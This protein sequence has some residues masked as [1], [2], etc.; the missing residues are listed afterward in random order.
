M[1]PRHKNVFLR[2]SY[3]KFYSSINQELSSV[4]R[5]K[6]NLGDSEPYYFGEFEGDGSSTSLRRIL[7]RLGP[8]AYYD[9]TKR[10]KLGELLI[11][12]SAK[13]VDDWFAMVDMEVR[14]AMQ[15]M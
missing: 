1:A 10:W 11:F 13:A 14:K 2:S 3:R 5:F 9:V 4:D 8:V 12:L 7:S 6:K 15:G